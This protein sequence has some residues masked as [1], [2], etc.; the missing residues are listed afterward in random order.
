MVKALAD[1]IQVWGFEDDFVVFKDGSFGFGFK[2]NYADI[3]T[4]NQG[5][6]N[7]FIQNIDNLLSSITESL[8]LQF[9]QEISNKNGEWLNNHRYLQNENSNQ[10]IMDLTND[11]ICRLEE[12]NKKNELPFHGLKLYVR[13]SSEMKG[14][15]KFSLFQKEK[16]FYEFTELEF[17]KMLESADALKVQIE[18]LLLGVG[19][20]PR[21]L[22]QKEIIEDI[23]T[24]WN[25]NRNLDLA[26]FDPEYILPYLL[27]SDVSIT[28]KGFNIGG[29]YHSILTLKNLPE[30]TTSSMMQVLRELPIN[31]KVFLTF[32]SLEQQKEYEN[33]Q[34]QRRVAYSLAKGKRTG[35]ADLESESKFEDIESL[36]SSMISH[37]EKV[38]NSS[39]HILLLH[40]DEVYLQAQV[41]QVLSTIRSLNGAEGMQETLASFDIFCEI[42][43]PNCFSKERVKKIKTTNLSDFLPLYGPWAGFENSSILLKS[44]FGSLVKFDPFSKELTN[45]NMLVSGGSGSGKSFF[46]NILLLQLLKENPKIYI[47]DI[48][49]SY[50]RVCSYLDG[51]YI[52]FG[53]D[54]NISINPFD[55][56]AGDTKPSGEKIKFILSLIE[57]IT[58][59]E[60]NERLSKLERAEIELLISECY[61]KHKNP[62]LSDLRNLMLSHP[63]TLI[64]LLGRVL[65]SWCGNT[66]YGKFLDQETNINLEKNLISF[67]LKGLD[68]HPDLQA[69]C[70]F[71]ITDLVWRDVQSDRSRKKLLVFDESWKLLE[72]ETGASFIS[73][74]FRTFRKYY[75]GVVAISQD[76]DDFAKSKIAGAILPNSASKWILMQKGAN[77]ERLR[78]VLQLNEK[79]IDLIKSLYQEKGKYSEAFLI[80]GDYKAVVS[81]CPTPLE[82]WLSTTDP[83]DLALIEKFHSQNLELSSWETLK[84]LSELY[85]QGG[86]NEIKN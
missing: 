66:T 16:E 28:E 58:K 42:G 86:M 32:E 12:Q 68:N 60:S 7:S 29:I 75:A 17:Q 34:T 54:K 77:F 85:P 74:V 53:V 33:L 30:Q 63:E 65:N 20:S 48:G 10:Q 50:K 15:F 38:F 9:V 11:R 21:V 61:E 31:S 56:P 52:D 80:S 84:K 23:Y 4:W 37:G 1:K 67:D 35:V 8:K 79:E 43:I 14:G 70:L 47:V 45:H 24:Q 3:S 44:R 64:K 59:E 82:Y 69:V 2:L 62:R 57:I 83:R 72:N 40:E 76:I 46:T 51:Q 19:L 26:Y 22:T 49:A 18:R 13:T 78:D 81:V 36:L 39:L 71:L 41:D 5:A 27:Y 6:I 25:P 73:D 55:L